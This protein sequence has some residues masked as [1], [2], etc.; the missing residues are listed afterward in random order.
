MI[1]PDMKTLGIRQMHPMQIETLM[2]FVGL[3]IDLAVLSKD[4]TLVEE[5]EAAADELVKMF[6]GKGVRIEFEL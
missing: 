5:T 4:E 3:A 6:G 1:D 2:D